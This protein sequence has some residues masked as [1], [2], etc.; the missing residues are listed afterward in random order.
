MSNFADS[1]L[2]MRSFTRSVE[3]SP[4]KARQ[5]AQVT[6]VKE[7]ALQSQQ[8]CDLSH[9]ANPFVSYGGGGENTYQMDAKSI[10]D[11]NSERQRQFALEN[12][13]ERRQRQ[14]PASLQVWREQ[15][16]LTSNLLSRPSLEPVPCAISP[17]SLVRDE[18]PDKSGNR[19]VIYP[20]SSVAQSQW[21]S[22]EETGLRFG[23]RDRGGCASEDMHERAWQHAGIAAPEREGRWE[24]SNQ[25]HQH[26]ESSPDG[27]GCTK[28]SPPPAW[29]PTN[30]S[31]APDVEYAAQAFNSPLFSPLA[32][33]FRGQS[34]P[35]T[36][37]GEK[38]LIGH[39]GWLERPSLPSD[40]KEKKVPPKKGGFL[41]SIKKIARDVVSSNCLTHFLHTDLL[42]YP[43]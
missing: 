16:G 20:Y 30:R 35:T 26:P 37:R 23:K 25:Y 24:T 1:Q 4:L 3:S 42:T 10:S 38:T 27:Q 40:D 39:K 13:A 9:E 12:L 36:K 43:F 33:Y 18:S 6:P 41:G 5:R 7:N 15:R 31:Q 8:S 11:L 22:A 19:E 28:S 17:L 2:C 21:A 29:Q 34:F 14:T 32:L